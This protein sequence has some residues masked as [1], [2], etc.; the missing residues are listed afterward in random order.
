MSRSSKGLDETVPVVLS[1]GKCVSE[2]GRLYSPEEAPVRDYQ[3]DPVIPYLNF[4]RTLSQ[5]EEEVFAYL[6]RKQEIIE[7]PSFTMKKRKLAVE[8]LN[9]K[10]V[11]LVENYGI[12]YAYFFLRK[13]QNKIGHIP[14]LCDAVIKVI[15]DYETFQAKQKLR[16]GDPGYY[17]REAY[18][19][20]DPTYQSGGDGAPWQP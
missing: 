15:E 7:S 12:D 14:A 11:W 1:C 17:Q 13:L 10:L 9:L 2:D 19:A 18:G 3:F 8:S 5:L 20:L 4:T 16:P 6:L